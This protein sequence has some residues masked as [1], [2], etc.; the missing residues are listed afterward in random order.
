MVQN[1]DNKRTRELTEEEL[2]SLR[3]QVRSTT[4]IKLGCSQGQAVLLAFTR[5]NAAPAVLS[6][7]IWAIACLHPALNADVTSAAQVDNYTIEGDLRRETAMNIQRLVQI[8]C[9]RGKR[10]QRVRPTPIFS[11]AQ[12][13]LSKPERCCQLDMTAS[14]MATC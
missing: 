14:L 2:T 3:Q 7:T 8:Q 11:A 1:I 12:L 4:C 5:S 9:H 13:H 6:K 10:H